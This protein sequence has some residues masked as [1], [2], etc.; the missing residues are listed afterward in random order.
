MK[1]RRKPFRSRWQ[2]GNTFA[3][4]NRHGTRLTAAE[5]ASVIDPVRDCFAQIRAGTATQTHFA[6]LQTTIQIAQEIEA[7]G[8]VRGL[9]EHIDSALAA[10]QAY[11]A[12]CTVADTWQPSAVHFYELDALATAI[13]LHAFQLAEV[14]AHELQRAADKVIARAQS[15]GIEVLR[16]SN[17]MSTTEPYKQKT[18]EVHA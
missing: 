11:A 5:I 3:T 4:I 1:G 18:Q 12:R 9:A 7:Q 14:T 13:D 17:D 8:V 15:A 6:V 10:S 16:S 2:K